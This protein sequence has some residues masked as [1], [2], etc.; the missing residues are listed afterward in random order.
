MSGEAD[1]HVVSNCIHTKNDFGAFSLSSPDARLFVFIATSGS[2]R[3]I[4]VGPVRDTAPGMESMQ[5]FSR[6][7]DEYK[8]DYHTVATWYS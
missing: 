5:R 2:K 4:D 3:D 7:V 1:F 6:H 8:Y